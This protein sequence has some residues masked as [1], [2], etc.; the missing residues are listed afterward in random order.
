VSFRRC[1]NVAGVRGLIRASGCGFG[2]LLAPLHHGLRTGPY[3]S[4]ASVYHLTCGQ[5]LKCVQLPRRSNDSP[6]ITNMPPYIRAETIAGSGPAIG[7]RPLELRCSNG[8]G[9]V[10]PN[11]V[12]HNRFGMAWWRG[13]TCQRLSLGVSTITASASAGTFSHT[14]R[15]LRAPFRAKGLSGGPFGRATAAA[16][17][18]NHAGCAAPNSFLRRVFQDSKCSNARNQAGP[19]G[20]ETG[21]TE[22]NKSR[23]IFS[24]G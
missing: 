19:L 11:T 24:P 16:G 12:T 17:L 18:G 7:L 8:I 3:G 4:L 22:G 14:L 23:V 21:A 2:T 6:P 5:R 15:S 1:R 20:K 13:R 10:S 9:G